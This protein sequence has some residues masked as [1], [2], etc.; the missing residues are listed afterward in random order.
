MRLHHL[1]YEQPVGEITTRRLGGSHLHHF[2]HCVRSES[3]LHTLHTPAVSIERGSSRAPRN[4]VPDGGICVLWYQRDAIADPY[5]VPPLEN[6]EDN[7]SME[8][9]QSNAPYEKNAVYR[10]QSSQKR[11][12]TYIHGSE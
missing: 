10:P 12:S 3:M 7:T 6:V 9:P 5:Y 8:Q 11:Y 4:Y 2:R 1:I